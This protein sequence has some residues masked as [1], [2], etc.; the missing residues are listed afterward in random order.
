MKIVSRAGVLAFVLAVVV[1][2]L[3]QS[4]KSWIVANLTPEVT[5]PLLGPLKLTLIENAGISF[6]L[7]QSGGWARWALAG[8]ALIV[9]AALAWWV[10]KSEKLYTGFA[11]GLLIGGALGNF[12]DR[13]RFGSVV[14]FVDARDLFF[15]W[16]FNLADSAITVGIVLLLI[17]S[18]L[19][20]KRPAA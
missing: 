5:T 12:L 15:P 2:L 16:I 17:E 6:G 1:A 18:V 14:D 9:A 3:D 4:A 7:L 10:R 8:F 20:A 13:V 19:P 11:I